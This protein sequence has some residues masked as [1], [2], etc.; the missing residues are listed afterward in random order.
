MAHAIKIII[1]IICTRIEKIVEEELSDGQCM[2]RR[3]K[4]TRDAIFNLRI[5]IEKQIDFNTTMKVTVKKERVIIRKGVR[6]VVHSH[7]FCLI[8]ISNSILKKLE[9]HCKEIKYA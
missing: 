7:Y 8:S 3:N 5:L 4:I 9:K 2:F 6:Q 1:K